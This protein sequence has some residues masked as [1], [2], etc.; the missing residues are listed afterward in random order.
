MAPDVCTRLSGRWAMQVRKLGG[1]ASFFVVVLIAGGAMRCSRGSEPADSEAP[2]VPTQPTAA[3]RT[4]PATGPSGMTLP[5]MIWQPPT[6]RSANERAE[7]RHKMVETQIAEPADGRTPVKDEEVARAMRAAPRHVFVPA[8]LHGQAYADH[9][10]PIGHGQTISQPY[11]VALMTELLELKPGG[12][13][14]EIGTGSGYQAAVLAHLTPHVYTVEIVKPLAEQAERTLKQQGYH[15][16][17]CRRADGYFGW[18]E[19]APFDAIIVTC[20]AGHLPDP[21]WKQLKTGGRIV[22][23]IGGPYEIQ[24]LVVITKMPDGKRRSE[25]VTYVR[26]VP[27][28]RGQESD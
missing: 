12:K 26:F 1:L 19:K 9:P 27:L 10:L 21:L 24:R 6:P 7:E 17:R 5:G 28:T 20:A 25:T 4:A 8:R 16:V 11:I 22:I 3:T 23:P 14:L 13:V 15:Q 18:P 2:A